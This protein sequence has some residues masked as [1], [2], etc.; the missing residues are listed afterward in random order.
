MKLNNRSNLSL[1][2]ASIGGAA[3]AGF[4]LAAGRDLYKGTKNNA[5]VLLL[6][7]AALVC[8]Y[9]GGRELVRGHDRGF[10]GTLFLTYIGS[11]FLL[12]VSIAASSAIIFYF[13]LLAAS[14]NN[15][16]S[17]GGAVIIGAAIT[18]FIAAI[19]LLVG[20]YQ[21]PKR[22]K[23]FSIVREN[24]NFLILNG[25]QETNGTDITHYDL[26]GN[27]LRFLEAHPTKI[28]FMAVG[29]RGKR[30]FIEIDKD[31]KM[32]AYSGIS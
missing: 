14:N 11:I 1:I 19:G 27:A 31:G 32:I 29:R 7:G 22:L 16:A 10:W 24:E 3:I 13:W 26:H 28:V 18:L 8:P 6:L 20:L 12:I 15:T 17:V 5:G 2:A 23:K 4:G 21:R 25:F 30:A 9:I